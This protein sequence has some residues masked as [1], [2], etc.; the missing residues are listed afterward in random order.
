[1]DLYKEDSPCIKCGSIEADVKWDNIF[2][3]NS[4]HPEKLNNMSEEEKDIHRFSLT[5]I[6]LRCGYGW[7]EKTLDSKE[8]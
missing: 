8:L 4:T 5:K 6:C 3:I 1:M 2:F 7:K